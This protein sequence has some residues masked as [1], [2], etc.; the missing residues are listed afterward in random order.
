MRRGTG[1]RARLATVDR[2]DRMRA[3]VVDDHEA[4]AARS[5]DERHGH[6]QGA[7]RRD[8][9]V[10]RIAASAQHVDA[11][12]AG[13]GVHR[14]DRASTADRDRVNGGAAVRIGGGRRGGRLP[15]GDGGDRRDEH[16][17]CATT[18][19]S[20]VDY[21]PGPASN[22]PTACA[23]VGQIHPGQRPQS[24]ANVAQ[25]LVGRIYVSTWTSGG[26]TSSH[27]DP[28]PPGLAVDL[29]G[30]QRRCERP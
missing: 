16:C 17:D 30:G 20:L 9:G 22:T 27:P 2:R 26:A 19:H 25:R 3:R 13:A 5:G 24:P 15:T 18:H 1:R 23:T 11:G 4:T 6:A 8:R 28:D 7:R 10:D 29:T 14:G 21:P 12:P